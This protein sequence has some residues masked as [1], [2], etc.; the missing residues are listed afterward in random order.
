MKTLSKILFIALLATS[1]LEAAAFEKTAT[2]S[3]TNVTVVSEEP[4]SVGYNTI[5]FIVSN[6]K[7]KD[8]QINVKVFMPAMPGMPAMESTS[9]AEN[10]GEGKYEADIDLSMRGT[11]Q[12]HIF[13]TPKTGKKVRVKTSL[14]I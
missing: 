7:Y 5:N 12:M 6:E 2:S 11:W 10:L 14:N 3:A 13:I 4:L 9:E 8:A 1:L